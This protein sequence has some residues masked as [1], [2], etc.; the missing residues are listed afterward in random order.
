MHIDSRLKNCALCFKTNF[1]F[2]KLTRLDLPYWIIGF[3]VTHNQIEYWWALHN[4]VYT[5][6]WCWLNFWSFFLDGY[7]GP[8]GLVGL[9]W[10]TDIDLP[11][12]I[13]EYYEVLE[14]KVDFEAKNLLF[15]PLRHR[16]CLQE[17]IL[18]WDYDL[19]LTVC[20]FW[21]NWQHRLWPL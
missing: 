3:W 7:C 12:L 18:H 21:H 10:Y 4:V 9:S 6:D 20:K 2:Q 1:L 19:I 8:V 11:Y 17:Q 13:P 16:H 5:W 14:E 15:S